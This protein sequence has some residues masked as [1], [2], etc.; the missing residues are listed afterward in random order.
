MGLLS[1]GL[2]MVAPRIGR[3][4]IEQGASRVIARQASNRLMGFAAGK[5]GQELIGR[6]AGS[7]V[8][9]AL[10]SPR[11][12]LIGGYVA[13]S[14]IGHTLRGSGGYGSGGTKTNIVNPNTSTP[15]YGNLA[16]PTAGN[17]F[18]SNT[19]PRT[20]RGSGISSGGPAGFGGTGKGWFQLNDQVSGA[21]AERD[22]T[23]MSDFSVGRGP[24]RYSMIGAGLGTRA[25]AGIGAGVRDAMA[26]G[27]PDRVKYGPRGESPEAPKVS[28]PTTGKVGTNPEAVGELGPG[29]SPVRRAKVVPNRSGPETQRNSRVTP[30]GGDSSTGAEV[31]TVPFGGT[32]NAMGTQLGTSSTPGQSRTG[33]FGAGASPLAL[34]PG[35]GPTPIPAGPG[36]Y[37][38]NMWGGGGGYDDPFAASK[39]RIA[40]V[41]NGT[42]PSP[43]KEN[44]RFSAPSRFHQQ[45]AKADAA[46]RKMGL[47]SPYT[48]D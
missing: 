11:G 25:L 37:A 29:P 38:E 17:A 48:L 12:Q 2:G 41:S 13:K 28:F 44:L 39:A 46:W 35:P 4:I 23:K 8:A 9:S 16:Q 15:T 27:P 42:G 47:G 45:A 22:P 31:E 1:L 32:Y 18:L 43:A 21:G 33:E 20:Q 30:P 10:A 34:A 14:K 3:E 19:T 40:A 6:A 7:R 26:A 36:T 5:A 24:S